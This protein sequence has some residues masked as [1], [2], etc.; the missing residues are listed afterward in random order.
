MGALGEAA[1]PLKQRDP[2]DG[3]T[4][5]T[6]ALQR[7]VT[8]GLSPGVTPPRASTIIPGTVLPCDDEQCHLRNGANW[9]RFTLAAVLPHQ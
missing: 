8:L 9:G 3:V 2:K 1:S 6:A 4:P 5:R 7:G